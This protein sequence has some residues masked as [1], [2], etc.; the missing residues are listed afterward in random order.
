M[1][2]N[3]QN[4]K[5]GE[6]E[7]DAGDTAEKLAQEEAEME[8]EFAKIS[9]ARAQGNADLDD[10]A[11]D[12]PGD[13]D[14]DDADGSDADG[15]EQPNADDDAADGDETAQAA[16]A[17]GQNAGEDGGKSDAKPDIW[18]NA[19]PEQKAAF[20]QTQAE[21]QRWRTQSDRHAGNYGRAL[22]NVRSLTQEVEN[23]KKG[24]TK[25]EGAA[26]DQAVKTAKSGD[27]L[28]DFESEEWKAYKEDYP[29]IAAMMERTFGPVLE[30]TRTL[31]ETV[32]GLNANRNEAY[33]NQ[34]EELLARDHPDWMNVAATSDF[35]TW[36]AAQPRYV[37]E[38][39]QRNGQ[40]IADAHEASDILTKFKR[41]TARH[42][43]QP[44]NGGDATQPKPKPQSQRRAEQLDANRSTTSRGGSAA[45]GAPADDFE[46]NFSQASAQRRRGLRE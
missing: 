35:A 17:T 29:D 40:G 19:T 13:E 3:D 16:G 15:D 39:A 5:A 6:G 42:T 22:D 34:Q 25:A 18:A 33:L 46:A 28:P 27:G 8:Q 1:S 31:R 26:I 2:L 44:A 4:G 14:D 38:A 41:E 11:G 9:K 23:F 10:D 37:Q 20:E 36:L 7:G 24:S 21:A 12:E 32:D 30:Q 43:A 45:S